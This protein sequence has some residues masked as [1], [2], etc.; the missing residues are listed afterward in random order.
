M[1]V[2]F[3]LDLLL[4]SLKYFLL[5][6]GQP[7][8][9]PDITICRVPVYKYDGYVYD[10][11]SAQ[12]EDTYNK[13]LHAAFFTR[14]N[15]TLTAYAVEPTFLEASNSPIV[16]NL[17]KVA[18]TFQAD[19]LWN[20]F[21]TTVSLERFKQQKAS[22]GMNGTDGDMSYYALM[23]LKGDQSK[24][25]TYLIKV[26]QPG[27][28]IVNGAFT[29]MPLQEIQLLVKQARLYDIQY[30]YEKKINNCNP[31]NELITTCI[32]D[33]FKQKYGT[34]WEASRKTAEELS[35]LKIRSP[36]V[37]ASLTGCFVTS[38]L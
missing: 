11:L 28:A 4:V 29:M 15:E 37:I 17:D 23:W 5:E 30:K 20:A 2:C 31:K 16:D 13:A 24:D 36:E 34:G 22:Q 12:D 27:E 33:Y 9:H 14:P 8:Q 10:I 38:G 19:L 6:F 25:L 21:C 7:I 1:K 26:H 3:K 32:A 18:S 35:D